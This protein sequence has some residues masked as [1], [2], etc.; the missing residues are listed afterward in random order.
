M[1]VGWSWEQ[2]SYAACQGF[3]EKMKEEMETG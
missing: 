2:G 3:L 1:Y